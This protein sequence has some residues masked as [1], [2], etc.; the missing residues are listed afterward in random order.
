MTMQ[1]TSGT[2][3]YGKNQTLRKN[4]DANVITLFPGNTLITADGKYPT[5][6]CKLK[7]GSMNEQR[8]REQANNQGMVAK[9]G[10]KKKTS[11]R[12]IMARTYLQ[13]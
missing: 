3:N 10:H 11:H 13:R 5:R 9:S 7:S 12:K 1:A 4:C 2:G 6:A 8:L